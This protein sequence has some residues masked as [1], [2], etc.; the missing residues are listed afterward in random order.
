MVAAYKG[1]WLSIGQWWQCVHEVGLAEAE[2]AQLASC[3]G[4][5]HA[6]AAESY[7]TLPYPTDT[8]FYKLINALGETGCNK[9][10]FQLLFSN[11]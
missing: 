4:R 8:P 11:H 7:P 3:L 9:Y 10:P 6:F 2:L 5:P 1:L